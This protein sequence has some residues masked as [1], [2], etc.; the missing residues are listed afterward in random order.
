MGVFVPQRLSAAMTGLAG[1]LTVFAG[2]GI[3]AVAV[4]VVI[5]ALAVTGDR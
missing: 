4:M 1:F 3:L 5:L 2:A